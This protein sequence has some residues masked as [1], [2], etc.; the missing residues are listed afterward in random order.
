MRRR[1]GSEIAT[2]LLVL[3]AAALAIG[4]YYWLTGESLTRRGYHLIVRLR[5]AGGLQKGDRV[6]L[7]GVEVGKVGEVGLTHGQVLAQ[8]SV[9]PD[10]RLPKDSH[11]ELRP[12]GAFGG[13]YLELAPGRLSESL[14]AGDTV[15]AASAPSLAETLTELGDQ[16]GQVLNRASDVLDP[17]RVATLDRSLN[18][19]LRTL[20]NV[21]TMSASVRNTAQR[22]ERGLG[23][24]RLEET[25]SGLAVSARNLADASAQ[26]LGASGTLSSILGKIDRGDGSLGRAVNDPTLYNALLLATARFDSVTRDAKTVVQDAGSLVRDVRINPRRYVRLSL[27]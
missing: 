25:T 8:I 11:A 26:L 9:D 21:S 20:Q 1:Q 14:A 22:V 3:V 2:G 4:G 24:G 13:R 17:Q 27:F 16:A 7:A 5:D 15:A 12:S 19:L 6:R 10:L 18:A 23:D